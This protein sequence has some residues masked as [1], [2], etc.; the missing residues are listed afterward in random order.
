M[1]PIVIH[2]FTPS[3]ELQAL[4]R[5]TGTP[6]VL[7]NARF[8]HAVSTGYLPQ[9]Q[10][11]G[12]LKGGDAAAAYLEERVCGAALTAPLTPLQA[13][14]AAG[15]VALVRGALAH[16]ERWCHF[17]ADGGYARNRAALAAHAHAPL[18]WLLARQL[19]MQCVAWALVFFLSAR[20]RAHTQTHHT[21]TPTTH[22]LHA[23]T[24]RR[25]CAAA[26]AGRRG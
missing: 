6:Y 15:L 23:A 16:V 5:F 26:C 25:S 21:R 12:E 11:G 1:H 24:K 3:L 4:C 18:G 22:P 9:L 19:K 13:A 10:H 20:A 2:Q 14:H 8:P 17:G 7:N